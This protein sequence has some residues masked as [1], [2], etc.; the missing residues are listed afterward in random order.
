[1]VRIPDD[2]LA[3][4]EGSNVQITRRLEIYEA[5]GVTP[6]SAVTASVLESGSVTV[7]SDSTERRTFE[8]TLD[9][10]EGK[11][12]VEAGA[13]WWDKVLRPFKGIKWVQ[14]AKK[15]DV[16]LV[17]TTDTQ[18]G[19]IAAYLYAMGAGRVTYVNVNFITYDSITADILVMYH[20]NNTIP[21]N[22]KAMADK[23]Y[24]NG[25]RVMSFAARVST[26]DRLQYIYA[27][28]SPDI[29][30]A[31]NYVVTDSGVDS[32]VVKQV[33]W[34]QPN[35]D[36]ANNTYFKVLASG[37]KAL[38][39]MDT[40]FPVAYNKNA[41]GGFWLHTSII[42]PLGANADPS[43]VIVFRKLFAFLFPLL[44]S[45]RSWECQVG[46][47]NITTLDDSSSSALIKLKGVD[48]TLRLEEDKIPTAFAYLKGQNIATLI[49]GVAGSSGF[50][51]F[52]IDPAVAGFTLTSDL[53][54]DRG[55]SRWEIITKFRE[56]VNIDVFFDQEGYLTA[57]PYRDPTTA[58][59]DIDFRYNTPNG[60]VVKW[61]RTVEANI[62]NSWM[63]MSSSDDGLPAGQMFSAYVQNLEPASATSVQKIGVKYN[64]FVSAALDSNAACVALGTTLLSTSALEAYSINFEVVA[65]FWADVNQ[66]LSFYNAD[67]SSRFTNFLLTDFT[68][69]LAP[70]TGSVTGKRTA[71]IGY[72]YV[73]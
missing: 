38:G 60:N 39:N 19:N 41:N 36:T 70:G 8:C 21:N 6:Y 52:R 71:I 1:M 40:H 18:P 54:F 44:D 64:E 62:V 2:A 4:L 12:S 45:N 14:A 35:N 42:P 28:A 63:V 47:F 20:P 67:F 31:T 7:S 51:K 46:E 59:A 24:L 32:A 30:S 23:F 3:A 13:F 5:D 26:T 34:T 72:N 22:V 56:N 69:D 73:R 16:I 53:A 43:I 48:Y 27:D 17:G 10:S 37:A 66:I 49:K 11:L 58:E 33:A 9:N 68:I 15:P 55:T 65:I 50:T 25:G 57:Q 29:A 61:D